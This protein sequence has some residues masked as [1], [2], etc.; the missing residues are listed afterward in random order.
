[1]SG[2]IETQYD[3]AG[4]RRGVGA[5]AAPDLALWPQPSAAAIGS[6]FQPRGDAMVAGARQY[7]QGAHRNLGNAAP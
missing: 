2:L 5:Q 7:H 3:Q 1:V 4:K 6:E